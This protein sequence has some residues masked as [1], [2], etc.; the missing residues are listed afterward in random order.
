M[1]IDQLL[2]NRSNPDQRMV[3]DDY[4]KENGLSTTEDWLIT[5]EC[6]GYGDGGGD[7]GDGG[8]G[9]GG[10]GGYGY[11]GYGGD[12]DGYGGGDGDGGGGYGDGGGGYGASTNPNKIS[13]VGDMQTGL[14]VLSI[15]GAAYRYLLVGW[16]KRREGD[17][18]EV[19][20]ARCIRRQGTNWSEAEL[21]EK[22]PIATTQLNAMSKI[23]EIHRLHVRR[24]IPCVES[25]WEKE[26]PKP[27]NWVSD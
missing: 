14:R 13:K 15:G 22:G 19:F 7:D 4:Q 17:E 10:Y 11:G 16:C 6:S 27:E 12:G 2:A 24:S 9:D 25:V 18:W 20:N 3:L 5:T 23:E 21:A 1:L 26:C 8:G